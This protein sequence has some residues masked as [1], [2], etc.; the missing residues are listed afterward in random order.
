MRYCGLGSWCV[1]GMFWAKILVTVSLTCKDNTQ[2][3]A[4]HAQT[5]A[6]HRPHIHATAETV[7]SSNGTCG[8]YRCRCDGR[9]R[10]SGSVVE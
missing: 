5:C 6:Q 9:L 7:V 2:E 4:A 10:S 1:G 3:V 8:E